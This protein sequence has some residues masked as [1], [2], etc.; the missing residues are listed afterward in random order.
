MNPLYICLAVYNEERNL[1]KCLYSINQSI[2]EIKNPIK[3]IICLNG[4][5]DNSLSITKKCKKSFPSLDILITKSK[6]GKL[7]AQE[8]MVSLVPINS[9][10]FFIDSDTEVSI[11]SMQILLKEMDKHKE[12]LA[13]GAFPVARK[14][15][16]LNLWKKLLDNILNI[17]SRHPMAEISK[18]DVSEYHKLAKEDPQTKNTNKEHELKSKIFFHGRLF[19]LRSK[20]YWNM[21]PKTK[22]VVGDDSY[23]PDNIIYNYGKNRI[24]IRYNAIIYFEPFTLLHVHYGA[25]KRIYYDLKNLKSN[26]P[27][28]KEIRDH[29]VLV[30]DKN[31]IKMQPLSV[32]IKF[33]IFSYVRNL[34]KFLYQLSSEKNPDNI[35]AQKY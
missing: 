20:K 34:E 13:I 31:Y 16:G 29:S 11:D 4:C 18:L 9:R 35:W 1:E 12:L 10:I 30:L 32:R 8:K 6:R 3:T 24:R 22:E 14:Y 15:V 27:E 17:R 25:Y 19:L 23:L 28:F 26:S 7:N 21:P 2:E 5:T 33:R